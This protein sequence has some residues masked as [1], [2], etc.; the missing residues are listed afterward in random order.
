MEKKWGRKKGR[1]KRTSKSRN[2]H[3]M[4]VK[5]KYFMMTFEITIKQEREKFISLELT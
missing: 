3:K 5:E 1:E 2:K 4:S